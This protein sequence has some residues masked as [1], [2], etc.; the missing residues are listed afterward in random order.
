MFWFALS[1]LAFVR[2]RDDPRSGTAL[3]F[4]TSAAAAVLTKD[5]AYGLYVLPGLFLALRSVRQVQQ[6]AAHRLAPAGRDRRGDRARRDQLPTL[7]RRRDASRRICTPS[8]RHPGHLRLHRRELGR[9]CQPGDLRPS[10][11]RLDLQR[12]PRRDRD[13]GRRFLPCS[14]LSRFEVRNGSTRGPAAIPAF[15]RPLLARPARLPLRPVLPARRMDPRRSSPA[16]R[17]RGGS[18]LSRARPLARWPRPPSRS[19][20]ADA[21]LR[22]LAVDVAMVSDRR[23]ELE[24]IDPRRGASGVLRPRSSPAARLR[25]PSRATRRKRRADVTQPVRSGRDPGARPG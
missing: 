6:R 19:P 18:P 11:H 17:S 20:S 10:S 24:E 3:A 2:Y 7:A 23:G 4:G 8:L 12:P 14:S 13:A 1:V 21:L 25:P 15:V 16:S 9:H 22:V 5:Q